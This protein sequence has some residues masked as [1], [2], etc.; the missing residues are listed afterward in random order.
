MKTPN[1]SQYYSI[2]LLDFFFL[3]YVLFSETPSTTLWRDTY[4][5]HFVPITFLLH[6][7]E[8]R[9]IIDYGDTYTS[10]F[11]LSSLYLL[12]VLSKRPLTLLL[13]TA[14]R[15]LLPTSI[16]GHSPM[17]IRYSCLLVWFDAVN[18]VQFREANKL[19]LRPSH[20]QTCMK[21]S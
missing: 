15:T 21:I 12:I 9:L 19:S 10:S 16:P 2:L 17:Q 3:F 14:D 1:Y 4:I 8:Y 7:L 20:M 13:R 18:C 11:N 6:K 5:L